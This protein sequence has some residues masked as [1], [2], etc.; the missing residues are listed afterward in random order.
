[1]G[2]CA[3]GY[4]RFVVGGINVFR[5]R[6]WV[7]DG[8]WPKIWPK[9]VW[10]RRTCELPRKLPESG[11]IFLKSH[12]NAKIE[13]KKSYNSPQTAR[14]GNTSVWDICEIVQITV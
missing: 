1:M 3:P 9:S 8:G 2:S 11:M 14:N 12:K 6:G 4:P 5:G 7:R 10:T 13:E